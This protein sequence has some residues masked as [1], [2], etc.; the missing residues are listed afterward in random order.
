MK[1]NTDPNGLL[2]AGFLVG[3]FVLHWVALAGG[4]ALVKY[5]GGFGLADPWGESEADHAV[6]LQLVPEEPF[7]VVEIQRPKQEKVPDRARFRS[8]FN[9]D[10]KKETAARIRGLHPMAT[11]VAMV[12]REPPVTPELV[13]PRPKPPSKGITAEPTTDPSPLVMRTAPKKRK[14]SSDRKSFIWKRKLTLRDLKPENGVLQKVIPGAFPDYLKDIDKGDET[15]LKTKEWKY[16]SFFNRVKRAVAQ[17]WH[18]DREYTR[19]DPKGNVYGFKTRTT[20]LHIL[21]HPGGSLKKIVLE[22]P[23][24]LTFLDDEAIKAFKKAAPF[25]NP[26]RR[27]VNRKTR[28]IAFRFGFIFEILRSPRWRVIRLK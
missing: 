9:S 4:A 14:E 12:S 27:L 3:A 22:R 26:P 23:C 8:E 10:V 2:I 15:L 18:P 1:R 6:Q 13:E 25:P 17:H 7:Q 20:I 24:G 28:Q 19:R 11:A 5:F 21:L 16:A